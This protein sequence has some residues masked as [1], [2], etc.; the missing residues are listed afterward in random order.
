MSADNYNVIWKDPSGTGYR[1]TCEFASD[2]TWE[3]GERNGEPRGRFFEQL[4]DAMQY[5]REEYS[6]YGV[7]CMFKTSTTE[8]EG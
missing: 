7:V 3:L 5:A 8:A 1:V 2:D 6:E 4:D